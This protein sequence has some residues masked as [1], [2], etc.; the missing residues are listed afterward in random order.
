[1]GMSPEW[2]RTARVLRRSGFG[3][4]GAEVDAV[5]DVAG[6]LRAALTA[7]PED[8][9]GARANPL[10]RFT[11]PAPLGKGATVEARKQYRAQ[12]TGQL[13]TLTWWWL[14]RMAAVQVPVREKLTLVWH[15]HFATSA[16]KVRDAAEMAA[17]NQTLR[18]HGV[19]DFT[20]L[21]YAMLTDPAMLRWL[22]G[23]GNTAKAP[24]EN[25]SR[26]FMELFALGHGNGYTETDVREGARALTGWTIT[27]GVATLEAKRHDGGVKTVLGV[28]GPLDAKGFCDAVLARPE[29]ARFVA[30]SLWQSLASD[31]PPSD[32]ALNRLTAAYGPGRDLSAL[33]TA[34][35]TD[36]EFTSARD[37]VVHGPVEWLIG[38]VRALRVPLTDDVSAR[39]L[40][41]TLR[42]L[43]QLPFYP[44]NVG[45]WP[46][47]QG[48]M[49]SAAA[50]IRL[51]AATD[52]V[53]KA[54]LSAIT[55]AS[56]SSRLDAT[57]YLLGLGSWSDRSA[58]VLNTVLD[59]PPRLV[60]LAINTPEYLT[61]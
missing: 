9:P 11:P 1:M 54:D 58:K 28:T 51:T 39:A 43:G 34:I 48:W 22:D 35:L 61:S 50:Q 38:A 25:L 24:N 14:R 20:T 56:R 59:Q 19:G 31:D 40:A 45:G 26:E 46:R 53:K 27:G 6:Y 30:A 8:D 55:Q 29:S 16:T 41:G 4:T 42:K 37:T 49:S 52:L 17:Q 47:G 60:A 44:P 32:A 36:A 15:N 3:T 13:D 5:T 18:T 57:A 7:D 33:I 21:A 2:M 12:L 10:P 23:V